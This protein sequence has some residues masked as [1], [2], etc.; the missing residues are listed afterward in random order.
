MVTLDS[1]HAYGHVKREI[2]LYHHFVTKKKYLKRSKSK[3]KVMLLS[4][5]TE[6]V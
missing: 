4:K 3:S 1:D 6:L 2:D 5:D